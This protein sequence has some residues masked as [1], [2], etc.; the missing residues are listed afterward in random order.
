VYRSAY[1]IAKAASPSTQIGSSWQYDALRVNFLQGTRESYIEQLGPQDF[2][3]LTTYFSYSLDNVRQYPSPLKVPI[4]YYEPIRGRFGAGTPIVF[5]EVGWSS[6]FPNG[7]S[8]QALFLNRLLL[9]FGEVKPANV[10][11]A[12]QHD[13]VDYFPGSIAPLNQLGLRLV[14]GTPK[15]AWDQ[16]QWLRQRGLYTSAQSTQR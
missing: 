10:I 15:P 2:V 7:P 5:T 11:W 14:D 8:D 9:L 4:D 16:V 3:G 13:V 12:L 6:A 1:E